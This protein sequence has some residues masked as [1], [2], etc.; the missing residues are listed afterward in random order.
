M[1]TA[2]TMAPE[3]LE[4]DNYTNKADIWSLGVV[5]YQMLFGDYPYNAPNE[6]QL[7]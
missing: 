6:D 3:V 2:L 7:K 4:G 5:Y 1:G